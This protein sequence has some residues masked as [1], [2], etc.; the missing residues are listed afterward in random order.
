M[1]RLRHMMLSHRPGNDASAAAIIRSLIN[2]GRMSHKRALAL[3]GRI[4]GARSSEMMR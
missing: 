3:K 1:Y 4:E 2:G